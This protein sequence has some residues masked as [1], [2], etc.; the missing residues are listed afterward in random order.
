MQIV[1][2]LKM[3]RMLHNMSQKELGER[4]GVIQTYINKLETQKE[5]PSRETSKKLDDIF[6]IKIH[7]LLSCAA[8]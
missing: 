5:I 3:Q 4:I 6:N 1:T 7:D 8:G 2:E